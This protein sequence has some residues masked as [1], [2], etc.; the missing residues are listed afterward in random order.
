MIASLSI[1][2]E[3]NSKDTF[4]EEEYKASAAELN[5]QIFEKMIKKINFVWFFFLFF[6]ET[7]HF[8]HLDPK[9]LPY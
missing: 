4:P 6:K 9:I 7:S 1:K 5:G 2:I 3:Y 8:S